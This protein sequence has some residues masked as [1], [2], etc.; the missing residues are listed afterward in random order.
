MSSFQC[1]SSG[2]RP[3]DI[4]QDSI[5]LFTCLLNVVLKQKEASVTDFMVTPGILGCC[6]QG[7][8]HLS[9]PS[10]PLP[11]PLALRLSLPSLFFSDTPSFSPIIHFPPSSFSQT[12]TNPPSV[13]G[14]A[15]GVDSV[16]ADKQAGIVVRAKTKQVRAGV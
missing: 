13:P 15:W 7:V 16:V 9:P 4:T 11:S 14:L 5:R 6:L 2:Q 12:Y 10:S 3:E 1:P 8:S